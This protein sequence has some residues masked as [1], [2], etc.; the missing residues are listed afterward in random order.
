[1]ATATSRGIARAL[2]AGVSMSAGAWEY[3]GNGRK[4]TFRGHIRDII[5]H[6]C[7]YHN[8]AEGFR[9]RNGDALLAAGRRSAA[10]GMLLLISCA[11]LTNL[12]VGAQSHDDA[13][14]S[15]CARS[16]E[17]RPAPLPADANGERDPGC[18]GICP[19]GGAGQL[20]GARG[21]PI[22]GNDPLTRLE[23]SAR[24]LAAVAF[25]AATRSRLQ[26]C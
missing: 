5:L 9:Q 26:F 1:M 19:R 20:S 24:G 2:S 16:R 23:R 21:Q 13:R 7:T 11:N 15:P 25:A 18:A 8:A 10:C 17:L 4:R 3:F 14:N 22:H 12:A 6:F